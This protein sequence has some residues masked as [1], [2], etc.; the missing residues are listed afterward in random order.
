MA[1][2]IQLRRDIAANW[3]SNNP[4]L[5][6][7][8][9]GLE[10]DTNQFKIGNGVDAWSALS[11]GGIQGPAQANIIQD[12]GN[13]EDGDVTISAGITT[14]TQDMFYNNLTIEGTGQLRTNGFRVFVKNNLT[15][16]NNSQDA[17]TLNGND[18]LSSTTQ[19]GAGGGAA[20]AAAAL[21]ADTAGGTGATG[22]AGAGAQAAAS[23]GTT[24]SNGG[25]SGAGGAGGGGLAGANAGGASRAGATATVPMDIARFTYDLLRGIVLIQ[26]GAGGPGGSS[27]GGDGVNLGRG[28]GGGGAGGGILYLAAKHIIRGGSTPARSISSRG[29]KGGNGAN[30]AAGNVGGGGGAGGGGG[31]YIYLA[32]ESLVGATVTDFLDASGGDGGNGGNGIGTGLGGSGGS[33]GTGGR[34][35]V[36]KTFDQTGNTT[37]GL[38]GAAGSAGVGITGGA[39]GAGGS[40][41]RSL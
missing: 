39:G 18:G 16:L 28:G 2:K 24:P 37:V 8:E 30:G 10:T 41:K 26:G 40:C 17:I 20:Y 7:G 3:T 38:T 21:G 22:V 32:Y 36:H 23:T 33:G 5:A 9:I 14:L 11:Y 34:I 35:R 19:T 1:Q 13:G 4:I 27:G 25:G 15:L 6:Q 29:G 12:F 31:G